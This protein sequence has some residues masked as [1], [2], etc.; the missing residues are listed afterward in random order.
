MGKKIVVA[1]DDPAILDIISIILEEEGYEVETSVTGE[2]LMQV[3]G[4]L[5][6]LY[7]VDIWMLGKDGRDICRHLKSHERTRH[8]PI[9]IVSANRDIEKI[10]RETGVDA[11]LAKPFEITELTDIIAKCLQ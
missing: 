5:P 8:I 6:D 4:P 7:L 9:L 10:A 11:Y 2:S 1:D 3:D